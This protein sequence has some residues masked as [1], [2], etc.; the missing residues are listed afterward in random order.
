MNK[1]C[2]VC[3]W[4]HLSYPGESREF[5]G[6]VCKECS[7]TI[8]ESLSEWAQEGE[9]E[10]AATHHATHPLETPVAPVSSPLNA[11][12]RMIEDVEGTVK[13]STPSEMWVK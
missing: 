3:D 10:E 4:S 5:V 11:Y 7:E 9:E 1:R 8:A 2:T 12:Y 13:P 6:D